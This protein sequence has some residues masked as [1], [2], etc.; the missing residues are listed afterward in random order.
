MH[1]TQRSAEKALHAFELTLRNSA[2]SAPL[3]WR[4]GFCVQGPSNTLHPLSHRALNMDFAATPATPENYRLTEPCAVG[5]R[6][7]TPESIRRSCASTSS[8][9]R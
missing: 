7:K 4:V 8:F 5:S 3:R 6:P 2:F 9:V 1:T